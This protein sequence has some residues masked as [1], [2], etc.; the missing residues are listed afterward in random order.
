MAQFVGNDLFPTFES[1][2]FP[3][4]AEGGGGWGQ[5][6]TG[7]GAGAGSVTM[8]GDISELFGS[9]WTGPGG[10]DER[11]ELDGDAMERRFRCG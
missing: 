5:L 8:A 1:T 7:A 11:L 3:E 4:A 10:G 2:L 9:H 6:S